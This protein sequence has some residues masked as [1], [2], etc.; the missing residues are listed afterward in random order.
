MAGDSLWPEAHIRA[1]LGLSDREGAVTIAAV[2]RGRD[3]EEQIPQVSD[4]CLPCPTE[5]LT[6]ATT[7]L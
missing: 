7:D 5:P 3:S 4:H 2:A 1:R 6:T